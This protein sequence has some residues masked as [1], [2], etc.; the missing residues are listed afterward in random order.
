MKKHKG[1]WID[2]DCVRRSLY[3]PIADLNA[4]DIIADKYNMS[5]GEVLRLAVKEYLEKELP[6]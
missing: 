1:K 3:I 6:F 2:K 5:R 4:I